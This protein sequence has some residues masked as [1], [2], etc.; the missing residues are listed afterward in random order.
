MNSKHRLLA[1][2]AFAA[3]CGVGGVVLGAQLKAPGEARLSN[4][5][6]AAIIVTAPV[7]KLTLTNQLVLRGSIVAEVDETVSVGPNV[8]GVTVLSKTF[9]E[10]DSSV[11]EGDLLIEVGG[12]PVFALQGAVPA[13]RD[14]HLGFVGDDVRQVE[15]SLDR[16]GLNPGPVDGLFDVDT[17]AAVGRL[18]ERAGFLR[19]P[20]SSANKEQLS[21][22]SDSVTAATAALAA[23]KADLASASA[24]ISQSQRLSLDRNVQSSEIALASTI[25]TTTDELKLARAAVDTTS[26][27]LEAAETDLVTARE[28]LETAATGRHPDTGQQPT[29]AELEELI[30]AIDRS[31]NARAEARSTSAEAEVMLADLKPVAEDQVA[32][33][34]LDLKIAQAARDEAIAGTDVTLFQRAVDDARTALGAAQDAQSGLLDAVYGWLPSS[35]IMFLPTLPLRVTRVMLDVGDDVTE[36]PVIELATT[37][38][39]V[40]VQAARADV[41]LLQSG[42][43]ALVEADSYDYESPAQV[44]GWT[45]LPG[46]TEQVLVTLKLA[47]VP[48]TELFDISVRVTLALSSTSG[49]VLA[50]PLAALYDS[51][52]GST[53]IQVLRPGGIEEEV[54]VVVGLFDPEAGLAEV[55]PTDEGLLVEADSVIVGTR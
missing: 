8:S 11:G 16:L 40:E 1:A 25:K 12:R 19:P 23:A 31:K 53:R 36:G 29:E 32:V 15:L 45:A 43:T 7:E 6:P 34:Q 20:L 54:L 4:A 30:S 35:E 5:E 26:K 28:R 2:V 17:S 55:T 52:D 51:G 37:D 46:S 24:P 33:A 41:D 10:V 42:A 49:D 13:F 21:A 18:Y 3:A 39:L 38:A 50:V 48:D 9:A 47:S 14:L 22:A 27:A 44:V